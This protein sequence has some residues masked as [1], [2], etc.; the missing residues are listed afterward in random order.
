MSG[1]R[2][3]FLSGRREGLARL[4]F[5][6]AP[7][8]QPIAEA[9][10]EGTLTVSADTY[11]QFY[12][13]V[14]ANGSRFSCLADTGAAF[15]VFR[16]QDVARL[17]LDPAQLAFDQLSTTANGLTHSAPFRLRRL[18]I[19]S[20]ELAD[21]PAAINGGDLEHPLLGMSVLQRMKMTV[22]DGT[23]TLRW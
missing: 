2:N 9:P 17:G 7:H 11:G 4:G 14:E 13:T 10:A 15:L 1:I 22:A 23:M 16:R 19:A 5:D 6:K 18:V 8:A 12:L 3:A 20:C 21:I